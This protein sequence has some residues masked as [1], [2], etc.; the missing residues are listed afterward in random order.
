MY[1]HRIRL[2][3]PWEVTASEFGPL[4]R[5]HLPAGWSN[6]NLGEGSGRA[7]VR[8]RF[9]YPGRINANERVFLIGEG[10]KAAV[11][12]R[13][14]GHA[15]GVGGPD[16]FAFDVTGSLEPRNVLE[17][18]VEAG[19]GRAILWED[20]ALEIRATAWLEDVAIQAGGV[21]GRV[22]GSCEGPLELYLLTDG[23]S[24]GYLVVTAGRPFHVPLEGR[25]Q[26][27]RVELIHVSTVWYVVELAV[28]V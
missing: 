20:I 21:Q 10:L 16:R 7:T 15:I 9:G 17:I 5:A 2:R 4:G 12:L 3:G 22:V 13:L 25:P 24:C 8:R 23:Q 6:L 28:P 1:P 14:N 27:L 26:A 18:D 11:P 19:P